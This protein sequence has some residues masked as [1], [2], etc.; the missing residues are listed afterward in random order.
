[1]VLRFCNTDNVF[2]IVPVNASRRILI[3]VVVT[4]CDGVFF[5]FLYIWDYSVVSHADIDTFFD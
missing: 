4:G 5:C 3:Y 2:V 1:M